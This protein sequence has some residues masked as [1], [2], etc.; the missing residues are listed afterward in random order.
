MAG[1]SGVGWRRSGRAGRTFRL[2][3]IAVWVGLA[4]LLALFFQSFDL[5]LALILDKLPFLLGLRL[6]PSG[7]V[8]GA[9]LT[10]LVC[11]LSIAL[12][13]VIGL[14]AT[15]GRLS[16]NPV[17][18][19]VSTFYGSFFRGTPLLVQILLL[20]L[21]LPQI[22]AV[23]AALPCGVLALALNYGAYLTEIFRASVQAVPASQREAAA[24]LGLSRVQIAWTVVFPQAT[25]FA[26]PPTGAQFVAMLKDSSL[27]SVTG[28]W[29]IN[30][31]AQSYGR[32]S[33]RYVEMLLTAAFIYWMLSL[34][35]E[36]AQA[37]LER[38]YG[39]AY[40]VG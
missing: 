35:F 23:P 14:A 32:S 6:T 13:I 21:G 29:E 16:S 33:Y 37:H 8:Q 26:I 18:Y 30:F 9:A 36:F 20:Y 22:G 27:V 2:G 10:L 28:L 3:V 1:D 12:S 11:T 5:K 24:A 39:R 31:L 40:Q 38:R 25:R 4:A 34:M 19:G 17:A 7:F 15:M